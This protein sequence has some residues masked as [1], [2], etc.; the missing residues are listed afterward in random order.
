[1]LVRAAPA[2]TDIKRCSCAVL[3]HIC[4]N[5]VAVFW[6]VFLLMQ[7]HLKSQQSPCKR[8]AFFVSALMSSS[9]PS[10]HLFRVHQ[11]FF[12]WWI[13]TRLQKRFTFF[14]SVYCKVSWKL[15]PKEKTS[16]FKRDYSGSSTCYHCQPSFFL[17]GIM[18]ELCFFVGSFNFSTLVRVYSQNNKNVFFCLFIIKFASWPVVTCLNKDIE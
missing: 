11:G 10:S 1:M 7:R 2:V 13:T 3:S 12:R 6:T 16:H 5:Q 14:T 4:C 17:N 9:F 15:A 8:L 18:C